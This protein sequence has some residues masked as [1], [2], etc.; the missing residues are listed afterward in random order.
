MFGV[1]ACDEARITTT[2]IV[3]NA[4]DG[5]S[6]HVIVRE[7]SECSADDIQGEVSYYVE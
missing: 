2:Y 7:K 1:A 3:P 5:K 4:N 6:K